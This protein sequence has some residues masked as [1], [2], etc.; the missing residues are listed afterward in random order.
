MTF[1]GRVGHHGKVWKSWTL[2][3]NMEECDIMTRYGRVGH[4]DKVWKSVTLWQG[5]EECDLITHRWSASKNSCGQY[6]GLVPTS[7]TTAPGWVGWDTACAQLHLQAGC[8]MWGQ[9]R[10]T[11][12][13]QGAGVETGRRAGRVSCTQVPVFTKIPQDEQWS[14]RW[15]GAGAVI[16][17]S[18]ALGDSYLWG[19]TCRLWLCWWYRVYKVMVLLWWSKSPGKRADHHLSHSTAR[20]L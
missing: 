19:D 1:Y 2:W 17:W 7:T 6:P 14:A 8:G 15:W 5:M 20:L 12:S 11:H 4:Y 16:R 18:G 10:C 3:Q 13:Q 9:Y